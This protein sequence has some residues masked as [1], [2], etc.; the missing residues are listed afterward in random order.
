MSGACGFSLPA[1]EELRSEGRKRRLQ[2][3][4]GNVVGV[5]RLSEGPE[6]APGLGG[7]RLAPL[8]LARNWTSAKK[9]TGAAAPSESE[10]SA[11]EQDGLPH[12]CAYE[13]KRLKNIEENAQFFA[14]LKLH[15]TAA[16]LHRIT[17]GQSRRIAR[18]KPKKVEEETTLRRSMRLQRKEPSGTALPEAV[19]QPEL[20]VNA[21]RMKPP[22]PLKMIPTNHKEEDVTWDFLHTWRAASQAQPNRIKQVPTSDYQRY[23]GD[24]KKMRLQQGSVA[25]VVKNRIFSLTFLP[26]EN[27][28]LVA[29]GDKW[30][31]V[32]VWD[33]SQSNVLMF[34]PHCRPVASLFF[35]PMNMAHLLSLSY[36]GSIRCGDV[37]QAVFDEVYRTQGASLSSF[38]FLS[39][40]GS[41]LIV[42]HW[43]AD[44]VV[45]DRRTPGTSHELWGQIASKI[46]RTVHVHP[47]RRHYILTAGAESVSLYDVRHLKPKDSK[48]VWSLSDHTK[49]VAS[50]FF[51]PA[52]GN[53]VVTTCADDQLRVYDTSCLSIASLLTTLHHNNNTGRWLTRFQAMWDPKQEDCFVVGSMAHPRRIEVFH[54]SGQLIHAFYDAEYLCSVCSINAMHPTRNL[55]AGANSSGRVHLFMN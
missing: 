35:S 24:V 9:G 5:G 10:D 49:S 6:G 37:T 15:E 43:D 48:P 42:G 33:V 52:T 41:T 1:T 31:Q 30:G 4:P 12:L 2:Q 7:V 32:G 16:N 19:A 3:L 29:A 17:T 51:S 13:R 18:R 23:R 21:L 26:S 54:E 36:D 20:A 38:D 8:K 45:V 40:D 28:T 46:V 27:R 39:E 50:A 53:R 22:G 34:E 11:A 55:L 44:V 14:A 47:A 25:K